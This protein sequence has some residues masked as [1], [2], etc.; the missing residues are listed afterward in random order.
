MA[1]LAPTSMCFALILALLSCCLAFPVNTDR[2][3]AEGMKP[4]MRGIVVLADVTAAYDPQTGWHKGESGPISVSASNEYRLKFKCPNG[5]SI[6]ACNCQN[7]NCAVAWGSA[8][9]TSDSCTCVWWS[10][11][12]G[13]TAQR[14]AA[15]IRC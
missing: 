14:P 1:R 11:H 10:L 13:C 4:T 12:S 2:S 8:I 3:L 15:S 5:L 6:N 9:T 7:F